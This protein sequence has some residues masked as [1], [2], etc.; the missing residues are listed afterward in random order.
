ER[1][2]MRRPFLSIREALAGLEE[3]SGRTIGPPARR[4]RLVRQ[5]NEASAATRLYEDALPA[6]LELRGRFRLG[7]L[8]NTQSFDLDFIGSRG[9]LPILDVLCLSCH[10]GRLKPDPALFAS[11]ARQMGLPPA[12]ILMVGDSLED[13][14]GG[15][16][17][18]GMRAVHLARG[19]PA[20]GPAGAT[21]SIGSLTGLSFLLSRES[22][23]PA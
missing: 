17:A 16:I 14:V 11:A 8:S 13:D 22:S 4:D 12:A 23:G 3:E 1:G 18:A 10:E 15:A 5:W 20:C 21:A 6:L 19:G 2:M 7:V 9:L